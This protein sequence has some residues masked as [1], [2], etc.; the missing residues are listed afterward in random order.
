MGLLALLLD[1]A[2]DDF[3]GRRASSG[4]RFLV[5]QLETPF[6]LLTREETTTLGGYSTS[7]VFPCFCFASRLCVFA[8]KLLT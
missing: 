7:K 3:Q 1:V 5:R 8:W 6:R 2:M 4:R